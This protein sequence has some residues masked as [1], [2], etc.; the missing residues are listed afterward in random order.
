M[1]STAKKFDQASRGEFDQRLGMIVRPFDELATLE[2]RPA[3]GAPQVL[4]I[5]R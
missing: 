3:E 4:I 5:A 1:R 2:R